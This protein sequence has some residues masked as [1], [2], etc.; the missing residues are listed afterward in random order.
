MSGDFAFFLHA[1]FLKMWKQVQVIFGTEM[2]DCSRVLEKLTCSNPC[3]S[4]YIWIL[5]FTLPTCFNKWH[6]FDQFH[7]PTIEVYYFW[8]AGSRW[9]I[10][11]KVVST[12][13]LAG[14]LV[15]F[16]A[17][18]RWCFNAVSHSVILCASKNR[19]EKITLSKS[20]VKRCV[21]HWMI[22]NCVGSQGILHTFVM[23]SMLGNLYAV[24]LWLSG[25]YQRYS[26]HILG[27]FLKKADD[28]LESMSS[29]YPSVIRYP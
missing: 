27:L 20:I 2:S 6:T 16:W 21:P 8:I 11:V 9:S 29:M 3:D 22:Q 4:D 26:W 28:P 17:A 24:V 23:S 19:A 25:L 15:Q 14:A 10:N 7:T 12:S 5:N 18:Q 1:F 13:L